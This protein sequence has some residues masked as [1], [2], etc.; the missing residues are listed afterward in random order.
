VGQNSGDHIY[1]RDLQLGATT[2]VDADGHGLGS[3]IQ[4]MAIP[5]LSADGRFVA[6]ECPDANL[7]PNDLNRCLDVFVRDLGGGTVELDSVHDPALP[8]ITP[9]GSSQLSPT[10]VSADGRVVAFASDGANLVTNAANDELNV[11]VRDLFAATNCLVSIATNGAAGDG[12]SFD[13]CISAD[14]RYVAFTSWADN[15]VPGDTNYAQNVFVRDLR[16]GTTTLVSGNIPAVSV[17]EHSFSSPA[18]SSDGRFVLFYNAINLYLRDMQLGKTFAL[19][20]NYF[21]EPMLA[22]MTPDGRFVAFSGSAWAELIIWNSATATPIYTN[23]NVGFVSAFS[24][25]PAGNRLVMSCTP[26]GGS[27]SILQVIDWTAKTNWVIGSGALGNDFGLCFSADGRY[28][29]YATFAISPACNQVHRYDFESGTDLLVSQGVSG[30]G[31]GSSVAPTISADGRYVAYRS[32]ATNLVPGATNGIEQIFLYDSQ[33]GATTLV[34]AD[35]AGRA[36]DS[37]SNYP[38]FS[39]NG[40]LLFFQSDA[41]DLVA[42]DFN[43]ASDIYFDNLSGSPIPWFNAQIQPSA[44]PGQPPI[45]SFTVPPGMTCHAQ[46]TDT[47]ANPSWQ[48]LDAAISVAGGQG[49]FIDPNSGGGRRFYR[50]VAD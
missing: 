34:S 42:L 17:S 27:S 15:L 6:F 35:P 8:C 25:S 9:S 26:P 23:N 44:T 50:I 1:V 21:A 43:S 33:T 22:S 18:I 39:G 13:P 19:T 28:L 3:P 48:D 31:D 30:P 37:S 2:L 16:A 38:I 10:A 46:F 40:Q 29:A 49:T 41:D 11:Y 24:I 4:G 5:S 32:P 47:L 45:I 7:A 12:S 14:G 20:T 36:G